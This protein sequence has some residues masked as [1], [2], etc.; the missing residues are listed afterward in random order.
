[1]NRQRPTPG[2]HPAVPKTNAV[3]PGA[4][5]NIVLKADQPTG[6][7]VSGVVSDV[8]TRGNHPRG[9]KVRLSDGRVGRVQSMASSTSASPG[10][11]GGVV[12]GASLARSG[13]DDSGF[14]RR[15]RGEET[16]EGLPSQQIGLEA[17]IKEA[18]PKQKRKGKGSSATPADEAEEDCAPPSLPETATCPVCGNFE[19]DEAA[20]SHHVASH[21][22]S[23]S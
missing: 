9:I 16:G 1:M 18:R 17:F 19:G 13:L 3:I 8:L 10:D 14:G 2:R 12:E 11:P 6:R 4:S 23:A 20:V 15:G 21:F 22:D 5:V 7:T